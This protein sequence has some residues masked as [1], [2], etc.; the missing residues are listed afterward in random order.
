MEQFL[1][2]TYNNLALSLLSLGTITVVFFLLFY[3]RVDTTTLIIWF[4][5]SIIIV[6]MRYVLFY[7]FYHHHAL[8]TNAFWGRLFTLGVILSATIWGA[9]PVLFF[10]K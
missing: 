10:C 3:G 7:Y 4:S 9:V 8:C 2:D 6:L 5:I 1:K